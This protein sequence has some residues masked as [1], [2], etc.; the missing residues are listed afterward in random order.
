MTG[1]HPR[2][3]RPSHRNPKTTSNAA[4]GLL[5]GLHTFCFSWPPKGKSEAW[6]FDGT[7][8]F[9]KKTAAYGYEE[10]TILSFNAIQR[11]LLDAHEQVRVSAFSGYCRKKEGL[12]TA[13]LK[14]A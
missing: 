11:E 14:T 10:A 4:Q 8:W 3:T 5:Y 1:L 2:R 13:A 7:D 9:Y 6:L 12:R